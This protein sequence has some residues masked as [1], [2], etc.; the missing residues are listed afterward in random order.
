MDRLRRRRL[1]S[2]VAA[3]FCSMYSRMLSTPTCNNMPFRFRAE[4]TPKDA[5][6]AIDSCRR[7]LHVL[8]TLSVHTCAADGMSRHAYSMAIFLAT[9]FLDTIG[10]IT[11]ALGLI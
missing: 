6:D 9:L 8:L 3:E 4:I 1:K 10:Q 7:Q 5:A 11:C 2:S